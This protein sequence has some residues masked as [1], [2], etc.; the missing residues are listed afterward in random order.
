MN[1][2]TRNFPE[3][4]ADIRKKW[5]IKEGGDI[6]TFFTTNC[7]NEKIVLVCEKI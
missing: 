5:N 3:T 7:Q 1:I 2:T 4:V 6:Y